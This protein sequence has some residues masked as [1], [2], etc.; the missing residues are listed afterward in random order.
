MVGA[1]L[2]ATTIAALTAADANVRSL[3]RADLEVR[4]QVASLALR[5]QADALRQRVAVVT[6]DYG[7]KSAA[8]TGDRATVLSALANHGERLGADLILLTDPDGN[9]QLSSA[10]LDALPRGIEERI[11]SGLPRTSSALQTIAGDRYLVGI[12]PVLA[13]TLTGWLVVG[14]AL[15][16]E[17]LD[18][19]AQL[20][21]GRIALVEPYSAGA[22]EPRAAPHAGGP[23]RSCYRRHAV[24]GAVRVPG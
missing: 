11:S 7:F 16:R 21:G 4:S 8:A 5:Q 3:V 22:G 6:D 24:G 19:L 17:E 1:T 23:R 10:P 2:I 13:P 12:S 18:R 20:A 15:E 14:Q 9:V